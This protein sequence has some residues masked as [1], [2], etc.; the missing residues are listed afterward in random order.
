MLSTNPSEAL[1]SIRPPS[2]LKKE[3]ITISRTREDIAREIF[4]LRAI[5][6]AFEHDSIDTFVNSIELR[7][8][9]CDIVAMSTQQHFRELLCRFMAEHIKIFRIKY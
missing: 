6:L 5:D 1:T 4:N 7:E 8:L 3:I 2:Q 9:E